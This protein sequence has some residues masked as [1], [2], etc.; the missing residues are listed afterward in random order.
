MSIEHL[1]T[2]ANDIAAFFNSEP[3][4]KIATDSVCNHLKKF[5]DPRMRRQVVAH[6]RSGGA[7][8]SELARAAVARMAELD[9]TQ[10]A[11]H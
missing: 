9:A 4:R 8:L 2:M 7:G 11:H 10:A 3:D 6:L 1:V 5:W